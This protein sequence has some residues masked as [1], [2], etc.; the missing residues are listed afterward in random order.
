MTASNN[1]SV[2]VKCTSKRCPATVDGYSKLV[3]VRDVV[4]ALAVPMH[5]LATRFQTTE[6]PK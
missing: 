2:V 5:K 4:A 6:R 3:T 1:T